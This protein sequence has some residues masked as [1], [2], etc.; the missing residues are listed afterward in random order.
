MGQGRNHNVEVC[1]GMGE[2]YMSMAADQD[3]IGWRQFMEG[4]VCKQIRGIQEAYS[5]IE[6]TYMSVSRWTTGLILK[7]L[8][9]THG[10]WLYPNMQVCCWYLGD[11]TKGTDSAGDQTPDGTRG[12][13]S[14]TGRKISYGNQFGEYGNNIGQAPRVLALGNHGCP[15]GQDTTRTTTMYM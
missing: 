9:T 15:G 5:L 4:M 11:C 6:S 13:G 1:S 10:Q 12:I 3:H 8:E 7:L 14:I 2:L